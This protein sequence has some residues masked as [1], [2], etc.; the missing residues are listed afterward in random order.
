MFN[1]FKHNKEQFDPSRREFLRKVGSALLYVAAGGTVSF[2]LQRDNPNYVSYEKIMAVML[3]RGFYLHDSSEKPTRTDIAPRVVLFGEMHS[4]EEEKKIAATRDLFLM[5]ERTGK[6]IVF[7]FEGEGKITNY[8]DFD[9]FPRPKDGYIIGIDPRSARFKTMSCA[10]NF[11]NMICISFLNE[12]KDANLFLWKSKDSAAFNLLSSFFKIKNLQ[13]MQ[14]E[15][16]SE[17]ITERLNVVKTALEKTIAIRDNNMIGH[18]LECL[19]KYPQHQFFVLLGAAH[20]DTFHDNR[21]DNDR[22]LKALRKENCSYMCFLQ[23]KSKQTMPTWDFSVLA[24]SKNLTVRVYRKQYCAW[25]NA[26]EDLFFKLHQEKKN[27]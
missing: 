18:M 14:K 5:I 2:M 21:S 15:D 24:N 25:A 6:K 20:I 4:N 16:I 9:L 26:D 22:F 23:E 17:R 12:L 19:K 10:L 3:H 27:P 1:W 7:L 13:G 11:E 8:N